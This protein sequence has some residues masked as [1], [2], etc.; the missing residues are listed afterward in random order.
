MEIP[1]KLE[2]SGEHTHANPLTS[3]YSN[4]FH[5]HMAHMLHH[6]PPPARNKASRKKTASIDLD[7]VYFEVATA[8]ASRVLLFFI[9]NFTHFSLSSARLSATALADSPSTHCIIEHANTHQALKMIVLYLPRLWWAAKLFA[10][11]IEWYLE[12]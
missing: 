3:V 12:Q 8:I 1:Q 7:D 10:Q 9:I 4:S 11:L 5:S 2:D 6:C